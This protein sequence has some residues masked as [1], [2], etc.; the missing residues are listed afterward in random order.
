MRKVIDWMKRSPPPSDM[1][2]ARR[3][4]DLGD[5]PPA[6]PI[7][8]I[9]DIHGCFRELQDA[10]TRIASDIQRSGKTGLVVF[11]GDYVDRGPDSAKVVEHLLT[12]STLGLRRLALCGNHDEIFS[13]LMTDPD[14]LSDWLAL[15]GEQT[16]RSYGLDPQCL[17]MAPAAEIK[18]RLAQAVPAS[19]RTF[20]ANLPLYLKIGDM[21]FVHAGL[22]PRVMLED[23]SDDD[24]IWIREPF[25]SHGSGLPLLVIHGHTP[26]PEPSLGP[27]RIGI[28]TGACFT[29]VLT[30]LKIDGTAKTFL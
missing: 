14:R 6:H 13:R 11:L 22:R 16:L 9:G 12:P 26:H 24:L 30:V 2:Q 20:L 23:Q 19:H 18:H 3:R 4:I 28:D 25:L 29:G 5:E 27:G 8:A 10:E 1:P 17:A 21:V 7:Y 15:G